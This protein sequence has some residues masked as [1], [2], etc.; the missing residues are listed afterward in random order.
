ARSAGA[1]ARLRSPRST[2]PPRPTRAAPRCYASS[3]ILAIIRDYDNLQE[4]YKPEIVRSKLLEHSGETFQ[5]YVRLHKDTP[6]VNPTYNVN[7]TVTCGRTDSSHVTCRMASTRIAQVEDADKPGEHEDTVGRDG[8][9]L[10]RLDTYWR[11]E[12]RE[13]G[14]IGEWEAIT[15]SRDIPFLLRWLVRPFVERLARQTLRDT[16]TA[17]RNEAQRRRKSSQLPN[18]PAQR[19]SSEG[20]LGPGTFS[21]RRSLGFD[22]NPVWD[23]SNEASSRS[24]VLRRRWSPT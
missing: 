11:L 5:V 23:P 19:S 9:Y 22:F 3:Q 2:A 20:A 8:G 12:A 15:L 4:I 6:W 14:V 16:L 24:S 13:G 18:A 21:R 17:T 10:W 1:I 7:A